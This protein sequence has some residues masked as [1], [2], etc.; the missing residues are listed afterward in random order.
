MKTL[1]EQKWMIVVYGIVLFSIGLIDFILSIVDL[2]S[3]VKIVSYSI[4]VGLFVIGALHIITNL[5]KETKSFFKGAL[6]LGCISIAVGVVFCVRPEILETFFVYFTAAL[7]ISLSAV[8]IIKGIIG[9]RFK[10]KP[11][12]IVLYF[13]LAA[14]GIT[15]SILAFVYAEKTDTVKQIMYASIGA[16]AATIGVLIIVYGIK[17]ISKKD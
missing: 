13:V 12:W 15:L 10:Y 17:A 11:S 7:V 5:I 4:A 1:K 14:I 16:I 2:D 8:L 6:I 9:I 3:A